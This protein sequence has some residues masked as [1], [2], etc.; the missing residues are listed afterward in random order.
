M[1]K[2]ILSTIFILVS[3]FSNAQ[4][5]I[6]NNSGTTTFKTHDIIDLE[7]SNIGG[8][9]TYSWDAPGSLTSSDEYLSGYVNTS[10]SGIYT[11]TATDGS[12]TY[13]STVNITVTP[14]TEMG[15]KVLLSGCYSISVGLMYDSLRV[16]GLIDDNSV[17]DTGELINPGVLSSSGND[18]IVD[19]I[20]VELRN[21]NIPTTI[22]LAKSGLLQRDGDI[23]DMDGTSNLWFPL[24]SNRAEY[25]VVIKHRNHLGVMTSTIRTF[26]DDALLSID[27]TNPSTS[28]YSRGTPYHNP[29]PLLGATRIMGGK[30]CLYAGNC[31]NQQIHQVVTYNTS[32]YSDRLALYNYTG[33][34]IPF[35]GY[36]DYDLNMDGKVLFVGLNP[37][38][39]VIL[40]NCANSNSIVVH[41]QLP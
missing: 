9:F 36:S 19:W 24:D 39:L 21:K 2:I 37:D 4:I 20:L 15:L 35:N 16:K 40:V 28:L 14:A 32:S 3:L 11:A 12:N 18:A 38:R 10:N 17:Y 26:N 27:F 23:V 33:G 7:I 30:R 31:N 41:E 13:T 1:K 8:S 29:S 22:M 5:T 25:Y 6:I 34:G